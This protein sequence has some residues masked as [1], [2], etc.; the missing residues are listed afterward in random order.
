MC[1]GSIKEF[2]VQACKVTIIKLCLGLRPGPIFTWVV[3]ASVLLNE[4]LG[5]IE[6]VVKFTWVVGAS[7]I[8]DQRLGRD[9]TEDYINLGCRCFR[10]I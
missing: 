7:V 2:D 6:V 1:E 5:S 10:S 8:L 3:G 9:K 4:R